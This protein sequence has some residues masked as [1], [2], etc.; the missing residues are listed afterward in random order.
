MM[1]LGTHIAQFLKHSPKKLTIAEYLY[2]NIY[3][4]IT[5]IIYL[6]IEARA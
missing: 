5:I 1:I 6:F 4:K 2:F 3:F